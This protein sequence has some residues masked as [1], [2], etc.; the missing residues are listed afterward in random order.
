MSSFQPHTIDPK[1]LYTL[2][3][4]GRRY[5]ILCVPDIHL[6]AVEFTG[7]KNYVQVQED[8]I[9]RLIKGAQ[10][11][12]YDVVILLGDLFDNPYKDLSKAFYH[13]TLIEQ[14]YRALD[15]RL[16][17]VLSNHPINNKRNYM[18]TFFLTGMMKSARASHYNLNIQRTLDGL[19][20]NFGIQEPFLVVPDRLFINGNLFNF[21]HFNKEDKSYY[22]PL[23]G[24]Q[25]KNH[26]GL[27]HDAILTQEAAYHVSELSTGNK[28]SLP[29]ISVGR[30]SI[31][32]SNVDYAVIGDI[33]TRI[34][35]FTLENS[36]TGK[37]TVMDIPGTLGRTANHKAQHHNE[38]HLP[39]FTIEEDGTLTKEHIL[40]PLVNYQEIF[41]I[42]QIDEKKEERKRMEEFKGSLTDIASYTTFEEYLEN[43]DS[44]VSTKNLIR[45]ILENKHS[46]PEWTDNE[47]YRMRI[48]PHTI[49]YE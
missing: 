49:R 31:M 29:H 37:T 19:E 17:K 25:Y 10:D 8:V 23:H 3:L 28:V 4:S 36:I 48:K 34:G 1:D 33:H 38:V 26:I 46:V 18:V 39:L 22:D 21:F 7:T 43:D 40:F 16:F 41:K 27:Y 9:K 42:T 14:L 45:N 35:E 5:R 6:R 15:G 24:V 2:Y 13:V 11:G 30:D 47:F 12:L 44:S 32:M 20:T